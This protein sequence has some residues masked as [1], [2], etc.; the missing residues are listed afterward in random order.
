MTDE[1]KEYTAFVTH[2]GLRE[3]KVMHLSA[4]Q[5]VYISHSWMNSEL[6]ELS[7]PSP[8][9]RNSFQINNNF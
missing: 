8:T 3:F 1:D 4:S 9:N 5:V 6:L 2:K 7:R